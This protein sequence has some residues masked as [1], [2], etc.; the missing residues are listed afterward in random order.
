MVGPWAG[1]YNPRA[2]SREAALP[3][4]LSVVTLAVYAQ[5]IHFDFIFL[6]D[7]GYV[8]WN[9]QVRE[10]LSLEGIGWAFSTGTLT[11][12]HPVTWLSHMLD[13]EIFGLSA[14]GPHA[15]NLLLHL[16][17]TLLLFGV[18]RRLTGRPGPSGFVAALFALHPLHVETVAWISERKDLLSTLFG[19]CS[20]WLWVGWVE[21]RGRK[22]YVGALF[23]FALSLMS[24]PMLVT[25]PFL[26]LLLDYWPLHREREK[27]RLLR[28]KLAFF[29]LSLVSSTVTWI[30]QSRG[31]AVT[32]VDALGFGDRIENAAVSYAHYLGKAIWPTE[33]SALYPHPALPGGEPLA[34]VSVWASALLLAVIAGLALRR[35]YLVV[36]YLWFLGLLVP[37]IGLV[38]VGLQGFADRYMYLPLAGLGIMLAWT[39]AEVADR[40][41][42]LRA[43]LRVAA[44]VLLAA[45][46]AGSFVQARHWRSSEELF[47]H[48]LAVT[49]GAWMLHMNLGRAFSEEG[50]FDD[51]IAEHRAALRIHPKSLAARTNLASALLAVDRTEEA[52]AECTRGLEQ[53]PDDANLHFLLGRILTR[54]GRYQAAVAPLDKAAARF[55]EDARVQGTLALALLGSGDLELAIAR[56]RR[57]LELS[58]QDPGLH[59]GLGKALADSGQRDEAIARYREALR[60]DPGRAETARELELLISGKAPVPGA[61]PHTTSTP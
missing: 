3:L 31:G 61:T 15:I 6:D 28:E 26:F 22:N 54:T 46:A 11:N 44:L 5:V 19:L 56:Y 10:G 24:K 59:R 42:R 14:G 60:L 30:A 20:L 34:P 55:R 47:R 45:F 13:V 8:L 21:N 41:L 9:P 25:L 58:P 49:P 18:L 35:R 50:R 57:A 39:G 36:G 51:A 38:Q 53:H 27:W 17:N 2:M 29:A 52:I 40:Y 7:P 1:R 4:A 32:S 16:A 48:S 43:L 23:C 37:V 33:L 12:W